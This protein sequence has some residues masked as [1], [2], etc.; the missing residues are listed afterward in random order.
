[1][2]AFQAATVPRFVQISGLSYEKILRE[3]ALGTLLDAAAAG[4]PEIPAAN[5][6]PFYSWT[7]DLVATAGNIDDVI[8]APAPGKSIFLIDVQL[9]ADASAEITRLV[10]LMYERTAPNAYAK[11]LR[12][13]NASGGAQNAPTAPNPIM[14]K[15]P[16]ATALG[17]RNQS[18]A[19]IDSIAHVRFAICDD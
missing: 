15:L 10:H 16:P 7:I 13:F 4:N 6:G 14:Q 12:S 1:M 8:E 18:A 19:A 17:I 11:R 5:S 9:C 2:A 3:A